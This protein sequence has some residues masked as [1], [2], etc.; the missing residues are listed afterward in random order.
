MG[1]VF[2]RMALL[3]PVN[4]NVVDAVDEPIVDNNADDMGTA[5]IVQSTKEDEKP[6]QS[7]SGLLGLLSASKPKRVQKKKVS[8]V[9]E[10]QMS[11][12]E[13]FDVSA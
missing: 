13:L 1:A 7:S 11:L 9:Q 4:D 3:K 12:F 5:T 10:N 6:K 8:S 2:K